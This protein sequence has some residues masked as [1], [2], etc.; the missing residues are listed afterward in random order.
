MLKNLII[1]GFLTT[2][3]LIVALSGCSKKDETQ[4][5]KEQLAKAQED[6]DYWK[7]A[8]EAVSEDLKRLKAVRR[9]LKTTLDTTVD[10]VGTVSQT[11]EEQVAQY[12]QQIAELQAQI[13]DLN[14]FIDQQDAIIADQEAAF[15]EFMNMVGQPANGD[16]Q[17]NTGY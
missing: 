15:Q 7:G 13:Q 10:S 12:E 2:L 8:Y 14:A 16:V 3:V 5:L 11:V 1:F 6:V 17:T 4:S 9:D